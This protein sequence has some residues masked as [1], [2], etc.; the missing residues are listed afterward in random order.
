MPVHRIRPLGCLDMICG[1]SLIGEAWFV[2]NL[3][4]LVVNLTGFGKVTSLKRHLIHH[5]GAAFGANVHVPF[6]SH[7]EKTHLGVAYS[8][9]TSL[10]AQA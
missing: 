9:G 10:F 1:P 2:D 4:Y 3:W 8:I 7:F 5:D 6:R